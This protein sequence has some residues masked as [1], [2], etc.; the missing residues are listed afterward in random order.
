MIHP[1]EP[2]VWPTASVAAESRLYAPVR[3]GRIILGSSTWVPAMVPWRATDSGLVTGSLLAWYGRF[4]EGAPGAI[5]VEATGI[6]DVPSGPLLR[7]GHSRFI[8]GLRQVA[9]SIHQR[10]R[11]RTK[12][13]IQILDFLPVRRRPTPETYFRRYWRPAERHWARLREMAPELDVA[14]VPI[15][16]L[17][18]LML[19]RTPSEWRRILDPREFE[20]LERGRRDR[21]TDLDNPEVRTLPDVLPGLFADAAAPAFDAGFDGVELHFA[22]AYTMASFLSALNTRTDG[23]GGSLEGRLR[24]PIEVLRAVRRR[25][26]DDAL[27]GL[28]FLGDES[29]PGGYGIDTAC[30]YALAFARAG[31]Q[32]L[33]VSRGGKFEDARV[34]RIGEAVYPYTG[35][36]GS[37]CMPSSTD[38][39]VP[40]GR[41]LSLSLA[42]RTT[43][44]SE[45]FEVPVVGAGG[46]ATFARAE[47]ALSTGALDIVA[48]A[49]QSL[50]DPDWWEKVRTGRGME[51]RRCSFTNYCEGLDQRHREVT[52]RLWDRA[53]DGG[54]DSARSVDGK[55]RLIAP[56]WEGS[57]FHAS[58]TKGTAP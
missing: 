49:R 26:G 20:D 15:E 54:G 42:I 22:H 37:A 23:Y 10:S 45:G 44:R 3:V 31:A 41:N 29:I 11:G 46:I 21:V 56:P 2:T 35:D 52:C 8:P 36:S 43:L 32:F 13:F 7:I 39:E 24:L 47:A 33:S 14:L 34:P 4:A 12:A 53:F 19:T 9:D 6:R 28:R 55:R 38:A 1:P 25:V 48:A 17:P 16:Q 27:V 51:V 50:A 18:S 58:G 40:F 30:Q 57:V 5:V